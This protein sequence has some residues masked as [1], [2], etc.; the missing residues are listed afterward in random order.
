VEGIASKVNEFFV[1]VFQILASFRMLCQRELKPLEII[2][3]QGRQGDQ[4]TGRAGLE[5]T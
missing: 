2:H 3:V 1:L 4:D 5:R